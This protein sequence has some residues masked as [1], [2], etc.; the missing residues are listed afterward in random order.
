MFGVYKNEMLIG[1]KLSVF[2]K[3]NEILHLQDAPLDILEKSE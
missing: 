2:K 3:P 1:A